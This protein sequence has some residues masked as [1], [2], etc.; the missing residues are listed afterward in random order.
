MKKRLLSAALA[1]AMVL[2]LLPV[3]AFAANDE[4]TAQANGLKSGA[5]VAYYEANADLGIAAAGWYFKYR[6]TG[7][8]KDT[9]FRIT[10]GVIATASTTPGVTATSGAWY[11]D[12]AY[13]GDAYNQDANHNLKFNSFTLLNDVSLTGTLT[14]NIT[15]DLNGHTLTFASTAID[16][17]KTSTVTL[18]DNQYIAGRSAK[19]GSVASDPF[20]G[21]DDSA[22]TLN[23]C[24]A[25][26]GEVSLTGYATHSV[27]LYNG[28]KAGPI[29]LQGRV[30]NKTD[31]AQ[32]LELTESSVSGAVGLTGDG[33]TITLNPNSAGTKGSTIN[34]G[35]ITLTGSN[36]NLTLNALSNV[37]PTGSSVTVD[38]NNSQINVKGGAIYGTSTIKGYGTQVNVSGAGA[39]GQLVLDASMVTDK[40]AAAPKV[41][42]TG[43]GNI[44]P[45]I[46]NKNGAIENP[47]VI[48]ITGKGHVTGTSK[49]SNATIT[50][51][52]SHINAIDQFEKGT[53]TVS[54]TN[55]VSQSANI[56]VISGIGH[57]TDRTGKV[58]IKVSGYNVL[59]TGN[60]Q[61]V[62]D[63]ANPINLDL[64]GDT[65]K[66]LGTT[67]PVPN[68][69]MRAGG[70]VSITGG[71]F[72]AS[73][74]EAK[75]DGTG[76]TKYLPSSLLF[77]IVEKT[78]KTYTY[79]DT[80]QKAQ[81]IQG[82]DD[83]KFVVGWR[84]GYEGTAHDLTFKI[85][86]KTELI[87]KA[88]EGKVLPLPTELSGRKDIK[89]WTLE[90]TGDPKVESFDAGMS[91]TMRTA[92][93][94]LNALDVDLSVTEITDITAITPAGV[95]ATLNKSSKTVTL[96]GVV[97]FNAAQIDVMLKVKTSNARETYVNATYTKALNTTVFTAVAPTGAPSADKNGLTIYGSGQLEVPGGARYSVTS[98]F[99]AQNKALK[100][101]GMTNANT[102][103]VQATINVAGW[104]TEEKNRTSTALETGATADFKGSNAIWG[105]INKV[106]A[107]NNNSTTSMLT[108]A[109]TEYVK[110]IKKIKNPTA[111]QV[112]NLGIFTTVWVYAYLDVRVSTINDGLMKADLVPSYKLVAGT[113]TEPKLAQLNGLKT[114]KVTDD[115]ALIRDLTSLGNLTGTAGTVT[116][117]L[118]AWTPYTA[119]AAPVAHQDSKY[120]YELDAGVFT[121]THIAASNG[122]GTFVIDGKKPLV[123]LQRYDTTNSKYETVDNYDDLESAANDTKYVADKTKPDIV[124]VSSGYTGPTAIR[125]SGERRTFTIKTASGVKPVSITNTQTDGWK[126]D[127]NSTNT[128]YTVQVLKDTVKPTT[129]TQKPI[130][131]SVASV[132][133]G[134]ASLSASRADE[135]E[136]ITVT[137]T[138]AANYRV[139][140][141]TV[142]AA[143]KNSTT[144]VTTNT[145]VSTTA[146]SANSWRFVV[147]TGATSVTVTPSFV[148]VN[149]NATVTVSN[150]AVGGTAT[151][152]AGNSQVA[153]GTPVSV[154]VSP[155]TGYRTMGI[156]VTN[157]TATRTGANTFSFIVPSGVT[158]VVVTPRFDRN[159]GT[160][161]EDVW[162]TDYFS[163]AVGWAVGRGITNGDGSVYRFGTGKSCTREDMVTFLWRN[164]GSPIVT[165]VSNPFW[166]VQVGSY[167][168]NAVMWAVKNGITKGVSANQFGVGRAVTRGEAVTFLYRAA[169]EPAASTNSGFYDVPSSEY[170]AKAVSWAVGKGITNGD[171]STVKFSPNG[172]CLR[173]QIVTFMYRNATGTRA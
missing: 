88:D 51:T 170:Y 93:M 46:A 31:Y 35:A 16:F 49:F 74:K 71:T 117:K 76:Y 152:S 163:N 3:S 36:S 44:G 128:E 89:T 96:S 105:A 7:E 140:G 80:I 132:T 33:S 22:F 142:T 48:S 27:K 137:L 169:G 143:V 82:G 26:V 147:P 13:N 84:D 171:G 144:G 150:P 136:T 38:G 43:T 92:D 66:Y 10:D 23:A 78:P 148:K 162:S 54:G 24:G 29:T 127:N 59:F 104:N 141:V 85:G 42:H 161:F 9:Y 167:Y 14:Q 99:T 77:E 156:Y 40:A 68:D 37:A 101:G 53:L 41:I 83:T 103:G 134:S 25:D 91:I 62:N 12:F 64:S 79:V 98:N 72:G 133:G 28:A 4:A 114:K 90:N 60:I 121:V 17:T 47:N 122:L 168:Y 81:Q 123:E 63:N 153:P 32:T 164:A 126:L 15:V 119:P 129:P 70:T 120:A 107:A 109:N 157:A 172:Y 58:D 102:T 155:A 21:T 115:C 108:T 166:D 159:N 57:A 154:T 97:D 125:L 139:G 111:T 87:I 151:T 45:I 1:L 110:E 149:T 30:V 18:Y 61:A 34:G 106:V 67:N 2:T 65:N 165:G 73:I 131:I 95:T 39:T 75:D 20:K 158:N 55:T 138:P 130:A 118:G 112:Q 145:T 6:A 100:V 56:G 135:G 5:T 86:D 52:D 94:T 50:V 8:T 19:Q 124:Q 11:K 146:A 160:L 113:A 116:F 173:E 69:N